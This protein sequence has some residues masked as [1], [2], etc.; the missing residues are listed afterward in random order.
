MIDAI[1]Y[2]Y[3]KCCCCCGPDYDMAIVHTRTT[4]SQYE[5]IDIGS[6]DEEDDDT[7][8]FRLDLLGSTSS[9]EELPVESIMGE[10]DSVED[11]GYY[12]FYMPR[13]HIEANKRQ[14]KQRVSAK[15]T[16]DCIKKA[17]AQANDCLDA[18]T[19]LEY[20]DILARYEEALAW[21]PHKHKNKLVRE[22][23]A[24]RQTFIVFERNTD[25]YMNAERFAYSQWEQASLTD[26][27]IT[28][29]QQFYRNA[30]ASMPDSEIKRKWKRE[31]NLFYRDKYLRVKEKK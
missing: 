6:E 20:Y 15:K 23:E 4:G 11:S 8:G 19:R 18:T 27:T 28:R 1:I 29:R 22:Y 21:C 24:F 2:C 16:G 17:R 12:H 10:E 14:A 9:E 5:E 13:M 31:Y 3:N 30:L 7:H 25:D 26:H